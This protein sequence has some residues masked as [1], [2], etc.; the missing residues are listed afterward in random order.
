VSRPT[1][2]CFALEA[3]ATA[4]PTLQANCGVN[5][6]FTNPRTPLLPKSLPKMLFPSTDYLRLA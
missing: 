1:T 6:T 5:A 4:N 3:V 2:A